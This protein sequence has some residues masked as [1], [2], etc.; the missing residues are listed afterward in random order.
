MVIDRHD[1]IPQC[2]VAYTSFAD[3]SI[4]R[5]ATRDRGFLISDHHHASAESKTIVQDPC[6]IEICFFGHLSLTGDHETGC[7]ACI[8]KPRTGT[9]GGP[10]SHGPRPKQSIDQKWAA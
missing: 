1:H 9:V 2:A 7:N 5:G 8:W 3:C 4:L 6:R 10:N